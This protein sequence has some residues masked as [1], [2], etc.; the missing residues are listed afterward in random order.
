MK[1]INFIIKIINF[2]ISWFKDLFKKE[3]KKQITKNDTKTTDVVRPKF[4]IIKGAIDVGV[5]ILGSNSLSDYHEIIPEDIELEL[6]DFTKH[7]DTFDKKTISDKLVYFDKT[8]SILKYKEKN[9]S[10]DTKKDTIK[11]D[12]NLKLIGYEES[13]LSDLKIKYDKENNKE[14]VDKKT[15]VSENNETK[16]KKQDKRKDMPIESKSKQYIKAANSVLKDAKKSFKDIEEELTKNSTHI[17]EYYYRVEELKTSISKIRKEYYNFRNS[18]DYYEVTGDFEIK[19]LDVF[20]IVKSSS[21]LDY[22]LKKCNVLLLQIDEKKQVGNDVQPKVSIEKD[23]EKKQVTLEEQPKIE[24]PKLLVE[25]EEA[26]NY[27]KKDIQDQQKELKKINSKLA[28]TPQYDRKKKKFS[29]F[30][31]FLSNTFKIGVG[32]LPLSL[33]RNKTLG[34]LISGFVLNNRIRSMRK[35][36]NKNV[37]CDYT[38]FNR[39]IKNQIDLINNYDT[40]CNDSLY[41]ISSLKEEF[42]R[43]YGYDIDNEEVKKTFVKIVDLEEQI[44]EQRYNLHVTKVKLKQKVKKQENSRG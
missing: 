44:T 24:V 17:G 2:I 13:V 6:K 36:L 39:N 37:V 27:V 8:I 9:K 23:V 40:I 25:I 41:Q 26:N 11:H 28:E 33:F 32:L 15:V 35:I 43:V 34:M 21:A 29:F 4:P 38:T 5:S 31:N 19:N 18:D 12:N 42:I 30:D 1:I 16:V 22:Y 20:E 10:L 3:D 7:I 14:K